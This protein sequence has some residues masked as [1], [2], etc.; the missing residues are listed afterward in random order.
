MV[1]LVYLRQRRLHKRRT[2]TEEGDN[3]HPDDSPWSAIAD[4]RGHADNITCPHSSRQ[5]HSKRLKRRDARFLLL[6]SGKEQTHHL[7]KTSHLN[8]P[9]KD[10]KEKTCTKTKKHQRRTPY[11]S[12][13]GGNGLLDINMNQGQK[14]E[15]TFGLQR[16]KKFSPHPIAKG[17]INDDG[18]GYS[19]SVPQWNRRTQK[20]C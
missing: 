20:L 17:E 5:S 10:G 18:F 6:I 11:P 3:P 15:E 19:R 9:S 4:S 7:T 16:Y 1:L 13:K 2:R 14:H 8:K 12:R